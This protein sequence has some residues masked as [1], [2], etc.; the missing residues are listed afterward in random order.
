MRKNQSKYKQKEYVDN[1]IQKALTYSNIIEGK[2]IDGYGYFNCN[3]HGQ[4]RKRLD[5][6]VN[7]T[8]NPCPKCSKQIYSKIVGITISSKY[9]ITD[10]VDTTKFKPLEEYSGVNKKMKF[11]C[12]QHNQEFV[13]TPYRC[14]G[15]ETC[16][17]DHHYKWKKDW[18][19]ID[20]EEIIKRCKIVHPEYDYSMVNYVNATTPIDIICPK[21]G[22]FRMSYANLTNK[23][24]PQNCPFCKKLPISKISKMT[25]E[26]LQELDKRQIDYVTEQTFDGLRDKKKLF[27]DIYIP[28]YNVVIECQGIQHFRFV[29]TFCKTA[30]SFEQIKYHDKLKYDFFKNSD[31]KLYYY[32]SIHNKPYIPIDYFDTVHTDINELINLIIK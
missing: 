13:A 12:V 32:T 10:Y 16:K 27:I 19:H 21:H 29:K 24:K 1:L 31:I 8:H 23:T 3:I 9:K 20:Q 26:L 15:C 5:H 2:A 22:L 17:K 14:F 25:R 28:K 18:R 30:N 6:I 7:I 4:F 11:L